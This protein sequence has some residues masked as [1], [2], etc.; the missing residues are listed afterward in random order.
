MNV[1]KSPRAFF[2]GRGRVFDFLAWMPTKGSTNVW[3]LNAAA[4]RSASKAVPDEFGVF[5]SSSSIEA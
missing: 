3:R 1:R 4:V 5:G 2:L